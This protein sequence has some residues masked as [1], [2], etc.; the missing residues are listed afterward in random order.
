[1]TAPA[2]PFSAHAA[3][4]PREMLARAADALSRVVRGKRTAVELALTTV[5]AG[6]HLLLE[7]APGVG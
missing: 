7:D 1:M 3:P 4:S 2:L 6:G 5:V